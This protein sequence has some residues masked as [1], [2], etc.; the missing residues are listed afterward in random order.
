MKF[1]RFFRNILPEPGR[2]PSDYDRIHPR[3]GL[4]KVEGFEVGEGFY[5]EVAVGDETESDAGGK[6]DSG[7]AVHPGTTA[8]QVSLEFQ[9]A[10]EMEI[11]ISSGESAVH[12]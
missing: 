12:G 1:Y 3:T 5:L 9:D 8:H 10:G 6:V 4:A 2:A 11:P 7:L